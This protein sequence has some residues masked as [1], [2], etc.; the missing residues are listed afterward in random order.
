MGSKNRTNDFAK[1]RRYA[2]WFIPSIEGYQDIGVGTREENSGF[3][4]VATGRLLCPRYLRDCFDHDM[5]RFCRSVRD[6]DRIFGRRDWPSFLYPE[7]GFNPDADE[8]GLLRGP[9]L[10]HVSPPIICVHTANLSLVLSSHI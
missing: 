8:K 7:S 3:H 1:L 5:E 10:V 4:H 6:G 2:R 9:F